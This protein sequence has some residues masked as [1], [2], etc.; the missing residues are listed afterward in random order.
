MK[1]FLRD[2]FER[3]GRG[4]KDS[5][6]GH[7][8]IDDHEESHVVALGLGIGFTAVYTRDPSMVSGVVGAALTTNPDT[9]RNS[10]LAKILS[11]KL[12]VDVARELHYFLAALV[13]GGTLGAGARVATG[14]PL[15]LT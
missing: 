15:P 1:G 6:G 2:W 9:A 4:P 13:I 11:P 10:R 8:F 14:L 7:E 12:A 3:A 5:D